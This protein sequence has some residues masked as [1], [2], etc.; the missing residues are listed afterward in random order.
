MVDDA[1]CDAIVSWSDEGRTITIH[2]INEFAK[3]LLPRYF[4]HDNFAS[5]GR[6]L[7]SYGFRKVKSTEWSFANAH[8]RRG[9]KEDLMNIKRGLSV[10]G[11]GEAGA[12][13]G[14]A[15]GTGVSRLA[16]RF[17]YPDFLELC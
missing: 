11:R 7:N 1:S 16:S 3:T 12:G 5:F 2:Q 6:Q 10:K 9:C 8:F 4:K 13:A 15:E 14:A 17:P